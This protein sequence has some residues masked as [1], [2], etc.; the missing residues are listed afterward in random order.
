MSEPMTAESIDPGQI[1]RIEGHDQA[2]TVEQVAEGA[3]IYR[4]VGVPLPSP[5]SMQVALFAEHFE[6]V[7]D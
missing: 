2:Y 5:M 6:R 1:Y 4:P 3:V 7:E